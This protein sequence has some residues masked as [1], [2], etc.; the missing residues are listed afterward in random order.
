LA[1]RRIGEKAGTFLL[2]AR[3]SRKVK[4]IFGKC[5]GICG[6]LAVLHGSFC[7][8]AREDVNFRRKC[9]VREVHVVSASEEDV[10]R[11]EFRPQRGGVPA[12]NP[13][14]QDGLAARQAGQLKE[15][16]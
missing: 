7:D 13:V 1:G 4:E 12:L 2:S 9:P 14:L 10:P 5:V 3:A 11:F 16:V 8:R 15:P 6:S